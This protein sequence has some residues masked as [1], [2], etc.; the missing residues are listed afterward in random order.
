MP[1]PNELD[2]L[3]AAKAELTVEQCALALENTIDV[4]TPLNEKRH[5]LACIETV[6]AVAHH[7]GGHRCEK[8][9]W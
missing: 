1:D 8:P 4:H 6:R 5:I 7:K 9:C 3:M 2:T